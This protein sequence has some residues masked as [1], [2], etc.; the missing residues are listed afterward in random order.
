MT[1]HD[2]KTDPEVFDAVQR[3]DKTFEIRFNDR[4]YKVGDT[5]HLL[6]TVHTGAEMKAGAPLVYTADEIVKTV[7]HV[8]TGYGLAEGWCCLSFAPEVQAPEGAPDLRTAFESW[9]LHTPP[10]ERTNW[11]V[12]QAGASAALAA[13]PQAAREYR[14]ANPLGGPAKVFRAMAD[15]IE[16][17]DSYEA[18]LRSFGYAEAKPAPAEGDRQLG[19]DHEIAL[20]EGHRIPAV[21]AYFKAR[22]AIDCNDRRR[23]YEAG[24]QRGWR[25]SNVA[26]PQ[27]KGLTVIDPDALEPCSPAWLKAGGCCATAPRLWHAATN[28]HWHPKVAP[29]PAPAPQVP[30]GWVFEKQP[31]PLEGHLRIQDPNGRYVYVS[32]DCLD[33]TERMLFDLAT[34]FS[35][36]P[37]VKAEVKRV[38][39]LNAHE[40]VTNF[41]A[42]WSGYQQVTAGDVL[43]WIMQ[44]PTV[45]HPPVQG[46]QS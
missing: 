18:T 38:P 12:F 40:L 39:V 15:A 41:C 22:P 32:A 29:S 34:T 14:Q 33:T 27:P 31:E 2:L 24:Y 42:K 26:H 36:A 13:Q 25:D 5:L 35:Q 44:Q 10:D 20:M 1:A 8:L 3:G 19:S 30:A 23:V 43:D 9:A 7:S 4:D 17:G 21:D 37:A 45:P 28:N 11:E 46:S 16:A 6:K